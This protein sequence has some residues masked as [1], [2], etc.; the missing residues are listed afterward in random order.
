M[1]MMTLYYLN[2]EKYIKADILLIIIQFNMT[3]LHNCI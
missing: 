1:K 3:N 2:D